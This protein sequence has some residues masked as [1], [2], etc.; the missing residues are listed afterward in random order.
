[1]KLRL[2][3]DSIRLRLSRSDVQA[4]DTRGIVEG[5]TRFPGGTVFTFALEAVAQGG[6]SA[7]CSNDRLVVRLPATEVSRWA[8]DDTAVSMRNEIALPD[9]SDLKILVEKDFQCLTPR[10]GEDQG[11]M[12]PNPDSTC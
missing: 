4:A 12:F 7:A 5:T 8:N 1:V 2:L 3:D 11:D 9:G 10:E 6:P